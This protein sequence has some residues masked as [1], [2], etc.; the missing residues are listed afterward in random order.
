M[1]GSHDAGNVASL[2]VEPETMIA[3]AAT[4]QAWIEGFETMLSI[5]SPDKQA[6]IKAWIAGLK[7]ILEL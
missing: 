5:S 2:E 7:T 6:E 1:N 4:I 3:D